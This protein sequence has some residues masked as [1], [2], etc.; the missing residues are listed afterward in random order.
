MIPVFMPPPIAPL[1]QRLA[2]MHVDGSSDVEISS[3]LDLTLNFLRTRHRDLVLVERED[4]KAVLDEMGVQ[5]GGHVDDETSIHIGR[6]VGPGNL[7]IY[8]MIVPE[9]CRCRRRSNSASSD[10]KRYHDAVAHGLAAFTA[11]LGD[12]PL[13]VVPDHGWSEEGI[14]VL[15]ILHGGLGFRAELKPGNQIVE[16]YGRT[17]VRWQGLNVMRMRRSF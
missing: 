11:A 4:L 2:I 16:S 8:R 5:Y 14:K 17:T 9:D 12:N 1:P 15:D 13:G 7:L 10:R 3:W 6:L